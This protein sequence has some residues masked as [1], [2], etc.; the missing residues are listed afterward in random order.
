MTHAT[1]IA[2]E[3]VPFPVEPELT[4]GSHAITTAPLGERV[5]LLREMLSAIEDATPAGQRYLM[6]KL[7]ALFRLELAHAALGFDRCQ[8][9]IVGRALDALRIEATRMAPDAA[10]FER[11]GQLLVD[12]LALA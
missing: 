2:I 4:P 11:R 1:P 9:E 5:G 7:L 3:A 10:A 8:R 6:T 12:V